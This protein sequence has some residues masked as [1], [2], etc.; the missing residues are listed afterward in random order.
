MG[1]RAGISAS[2][3]PRL[4]GLL[5]FG[6][7]IV[8]GIGLSMAAPTRAENAGERAPTPIPGAPGG[9]FSDSNGVGIDSLSEYFVSPVSGS[10]Y[11]IYK[12]VLRGTYLYCSTAGTCYDS[13]V[14]IVDREAAGLPPWARVVEPALR[15][16]IA[17]SAPGDAATII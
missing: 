14:E 1:P 12:D 6:L 4:R 13:P 11:V 2:A 5:L 15:V 16:H 8:G 10:S 9:I 3:H 17:R 7:L